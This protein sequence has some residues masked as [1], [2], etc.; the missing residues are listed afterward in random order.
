MEQKPTE[1]PKITPWIAMGIVGDLVATVAVPT[2]IFALL[3][4]WMDEKFSTKFVFLTIGLAL[5]LFIVAKIVIKKGRKI[6]K[7]L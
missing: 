4:R 2:V 7:Q 1:K 5:A 3:G 6:A